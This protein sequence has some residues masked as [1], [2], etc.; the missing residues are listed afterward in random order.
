MTSDSSILSALCSLLSHVNVLTTD[1]TSLPISSRGTLST[2]SFSIP[3]ISHVPRLKMKLFSA[4]QLTDSGCRVILD[5]DCHVVQDRHTQ[6]LVGAGPRHRDSSG[7]WEID[8]LRVPSAAT[9]P[10]S[11]PAIVAS[12]TSSFQQWHHCLGHLCGSCL[13]SL[14][15]CGLLGSISRDVSLNYQGCKL[16]KQI[17]LPYPTSAS[18]SSF[19]QWHHHLGH[20]CGSCLSSLVHCGLLGSISRDVSLNCQGCKLGKQIQLPYPTSASVSHRPFDLVHSD[21]WG[22]APFT[23]KGGHRYYILFI[24]DFSWHTWLYF[25][26]SR[27]EVL[28]IYQCF[29]AMVLTQFSTPIHVF[30][31]DSTGE[32]ISKQLRGVLAEQGTLAQFSCPGAHAQNGIAEHKH[33]HLLETTRA[34]MIASSPPPHFWAEPVST[35]VY[36]INIQ[37][38]AILHGGIPLE[39]LSGHSPNYS[40]LHLFG[41]ICYV[42]LAPRERTK[43]TAQSV[44]CVFLGYCDEHKGYRCWDPIGRWMRI[45][46]DV[47]FDETC[48]FYPCP[49]SST[50]PMEDI[51]FLIFPDTPPPVFIDPPSGPIITDAS[52]STPPFSSSPNSP[53][54]SSNSPSTSPL[55]PFPFYYSWCSTIPDTPPDV[56]S[57]S[58]SN[59]SSS[60]DEIPSPL[61]AR[62]HRVP[63]CY[64]PSQY[65]L[66]VALEPTLI[67]MLSV[68]PNGSLPLPRRLL[69]LSALA[70]GILFL[71]LPVFV[72]S[73]ASGSKKLRPALMDLLSTIKCV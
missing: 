16:G 59:V 71:L 55:S 41:C 63:N 67:G 61:P 73:C 47:M 36:L 53:P 29:A 60:S 10:A 57:S 19:Q 27:S 14:V 51:S 43:L 20:L 26:R 70:L 38:S 34:M 2:S 50:Y 35:S 72:P 68:I 40:M 33:R 11:S 6:V 21:V 15:H 45:S 5:A 69:R 32:Y 7:L 54:S 9:S 39:H 66:S 24:D 23:S 64:S 44:E 8:W 31:A 46:H 13:S 56:P 3:D 62:Q 12:I 22:L 48:P 65:G 49:T 30:Y 4:S 17:Q 52:P 42:L 18:T 58:S 28:S 25:M 37:P 1:G